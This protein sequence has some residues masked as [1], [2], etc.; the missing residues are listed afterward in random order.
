MRFVN[1]LQ[2][3]DQIANSG[4]GERIDRLTSPGR[5]RAMT[6]VWLLAPQ[7]PMFFQGQEFSA[8]S[9]FL[10]FADNAP[11]QAKVV[12]EGRAKFLSQFPT[13]NST[14]ARALL[15]DPA[16]RSSFERCKLDFREREKHRQVYAL[17]VD[18]LQLRREDPLFS[19]QRSDWLEGAVLGPDCLGIRVFGD[20]GHDRLLLVNFGRDLQISPVSQ[21]LLAPPAATAWHLLWSSNH[22]RYGGCGTP[23]LETKTGWRVPGEAA[24]VLESVSRTDQQPRTDDLETK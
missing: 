22:A 3:H 2:N 9:P 1:F 18:L 13:L 14:E 21:P 11:D 6:A 7:T 24:V 5:L 17:H 20:R 4:L 16:D 19:Q 12:R 10:Y 23:A 15:N 8:S